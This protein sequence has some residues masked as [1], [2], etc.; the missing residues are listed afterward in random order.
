M[1][2]ALAEL[3]NPSIDD[4]ADLFALD[5]K[6]VS[7]IELIKHLYAVETIGQEQFKSLHGYSHV[8]EC[9]RI[10]VKTIIDSQVVVIALSAIHRI[11]SLQELWLE[12][13][14][15]K[16]LRFILIHEITN[17]LGPQTSTAYLFFHP[18]SGWDTTSSFHRK[19]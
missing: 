9:S 1:Y 13:E 17:S 8:E 15:G 19:G 18:F 11:P 16:H 10:L 7:G 12:F 6:I 3:G 14:V 4:S 5:A 2:Y